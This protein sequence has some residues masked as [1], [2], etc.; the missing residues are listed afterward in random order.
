VGIGIRYANFGQG[1]FRQ[2][3]VREE[4][5]AESRIASVMPTCTRTS[6]DLSEEKRG[7]GGT[8]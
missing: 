8:S 1:Q 4:F 7:F 3:V 6:W 5:Q 2:P